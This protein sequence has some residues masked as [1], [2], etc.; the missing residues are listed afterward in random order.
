MANKKYNYYHYIDSKLTTKENFL[1]TLSQEFLKCDDNNE[2]KLCNISYVDEQALTRKY[3][4]LKRTG[5]GWSIIH[6]KKSGHVCH[7]YRIKKEV[8]LK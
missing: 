5:I 3:N 7:V 8:I 6:V 1:K 4:K 2:N